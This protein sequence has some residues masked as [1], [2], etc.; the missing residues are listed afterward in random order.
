MFQTWDKKLIIKTIDDNEKNIFINKIFEEYHQRMRETKN[1][2]S[3]AYGVYKIELGDKG[4]S[5]V[6]VQRN[7][8]DLFWDSNLLTFDLKG[9]TVDRQSIKKEDIDL[10]K[11]FIS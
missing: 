10:K 7:M 1:I 9:S 8:N 6:M 2:L 11:Y 4:V 3:Y 5:N